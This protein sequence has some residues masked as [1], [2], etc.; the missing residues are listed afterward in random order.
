MYE[1]NA[2]VC[3]YE[4]DAY[5]RDAT[6]VVELDSRS[7]HT[8]AFAAERDDIKTAELRLAGVDVTRLT[9]A[10]VARRPG[11]V[12][13]TVRTMRARGLAAKARGEPPGL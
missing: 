6:L 3:G 10:M 5:W 8:S 4:V 12:I 11:W 7:F 1:P 9:Y 2:R 13:D